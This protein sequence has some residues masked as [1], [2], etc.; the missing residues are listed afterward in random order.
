MKIHMLAA[1]TLVPALL[2]TSP[3]SAAAGDGYAGRDEVSDAKAMMLS[4]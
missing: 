3:G 2:L 1:A 4:S